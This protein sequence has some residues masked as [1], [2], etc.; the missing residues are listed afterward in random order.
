MWSEIDWTTLL[1]ALATVAV[2]YFTARWAWSKL[3]KRDVG[4]AALTT[5]QAAEA[6]VNLHM[7]V[8]DERI[9]QLEARVTQLENL[10]IE[11]EN[12]ITAL[13]GD[14]KMLER[15]IAVLLEQLS[16]HGIEP[17]TLDEIRAANGGEVHHEFRRY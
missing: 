1:P 8:N 14:I 3:P 9:E 16:K 2:G 10:V 4:T 11:K 13:L 12:K 6:A 15:W 5:V 17:V 7:K